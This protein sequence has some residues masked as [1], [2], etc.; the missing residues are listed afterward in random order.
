[1]LLLAVPSWCR[2]ARSLARLR[3]PPRWANVRSALL[4]SLAILRPSVEKVA[5]TL[6]RCRLAVSSPLRIRLVIVA[7]VLR[8][9]PRWVL[10]SVRPWLKT[11]PIPLARVANMALGRLLNL[12]LMGAVIETRPLGSN[13]KW[14]RGPRP[15]AW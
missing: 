8:M 15:V 3:S 9:L 10:L 11:D 6:V 14:P 2:R 4:V 1:M 5:L 7:I 13:P 12:S